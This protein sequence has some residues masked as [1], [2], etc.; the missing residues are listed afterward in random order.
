M[1]CL[2]MN[3]VAAIN[4]ICIYFY[5]HGEKHQKADCYVSSQVMSAGEAK[6]MAPGIFLSCAKFSESTVRDLT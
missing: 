1:Y 4:I 5:S 3:S 2:I 6:F